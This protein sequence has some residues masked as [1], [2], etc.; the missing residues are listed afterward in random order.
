MAFGAVIINSA[1]SSFTNKQIIGIAVS[2]VIMLVLSFVDYHFVCKFYI[3]LYILNFVLLAGVLLAGVSVNNAT[4]WFKIGSSFTFQPSELTKVIMIV[5]IA[6]IL[7]KLEEKGRLNSFLGFVI[8]ILSLA[9]PLILIYQ[10]PDLSTTICIT[11]VLGTMYYVSGLSY[12][13]IGLILLICIPLI[14]AFVWYIQQPDQKLLYDH[15]VN[16]IMSFLYPDEYGDITDQQDNSVMAIGSGELNGKGLNSTTT[17]VK[18]ANLISEQQTDFIFSVIGEELGFIGSVFII[19]ILLLI[20]L[21]CIRIARRCIDT[22]GMLI[23][24]GVG[25]LIGYQSFINIAVATALIPNTGIPLPFISY[26]LSSLMST[27]IGIGMVLNVS[28][29]RKKY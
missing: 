3:A 5:F 1:D 9:V 18:E 29:Q 19:A 11:L 8:F 24:T 6:T 17:T 12:K 21:Q 16:R 4:R 10:Q 13:T 27:A 15:Q 23:A 28:L 25:C 2:V 14:G 22:M 7:S 26:G 20:V